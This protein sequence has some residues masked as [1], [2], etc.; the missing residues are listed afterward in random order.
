ML[1][2]KNKSTSAPPPGVQVVGG[3]SAPAAAKPVAPAAPVA[4]AVVP[5]SPIA[6]PAAPIPPPPKPAPQAV[7][8]APAQTHQLPAKRNDLPAL[9]AFLQQYAAPE[10]E[11]PAGFEHVGNEAYKLAMLSIAQAG[12]SQVMG[13][14]TTAPTMQA[15][16]CYLTTD[17]DKEFFPA[18]TQVTVLPFQYYKSWDKWHHRDAGGGLISSSV[19][20]LGANA[21]LAAQ[22]LRDRKAGVKPTAQEQPEQAVESLN[23]LVL[24]KDVDE[25]TNEVRYV[26]V[27]IPFSKSKY[28]KAVGWITMATKASQ[29]VLP[30][31]C[32]QYLIQTVLEHNKKANSTYFNFD[33]DF[34]PEPVSEEDAAQAK[35]AY[36]E[37][38]AIYKAKQLQVVLEDDNTPEIDLQ[39]GG[40]GT[41]LPTV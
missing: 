22:Q 30:L 14:E 3:A 8:P 40:A 35:S 15:G 25:T 34:S 27:C 28:K 36:D 23:F 38:L 41:P 26:P 4:Q 11:K 18:R 2:Q 9:P 13:T 7:I 16:S 24:F 39:P 20:P 5:P 6:R 10:G 21:R 33:V 17:R 1:V 32:A 29:N 12:S 31:F 37:F 19:D